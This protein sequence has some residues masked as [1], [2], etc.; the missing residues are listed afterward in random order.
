MGDRPVQ[1]HGAACRFS[2]GCNPLENSRSSPSMLALRS[3]QAGLFPGLLTRCCAAQLL[4][5]RNATKKAGGSTKNGRDSNPKM[6]GVKVYGGQTIDA[7]GIIVRQR[8]TQFH[9]GRNVGVGRDHTLF[10]TAPGVVKFS[11]R[12]KVSRKKPRRV[13]EV[14][15]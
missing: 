13:V 4:S 11:V 6:L 9:P 12:G 2:D 3:Q 15:V 14:T 8:G 7:G 10:A 1:I 5:A